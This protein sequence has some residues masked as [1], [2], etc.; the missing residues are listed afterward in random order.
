LAS[1][2]IGDDSTRS[3][4]ELVA[5]QRTSKNDKKFKRG[6]FSYFSPRYCY[7]YVPVVLPRRGRAPPA[8]P[9]QLRAQLR[10]L[11]SQVR[12]EGFCGI[13]LLWPN[14]S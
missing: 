3:I 14:D 11:L 4:Q 8:V 12:Y 13:L 5:K 1:A 9:A 10:I 6:G 7:K 2:A